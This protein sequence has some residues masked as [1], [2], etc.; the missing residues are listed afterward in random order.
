MTHPAYTTEPGP[1]KKYSDYQYDIETQNQEA[2]RKNNEELDKR[3]KKY[4]FNYWLVLMLLFILI[5]H[6]R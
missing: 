2:L 5:Y 4:L 6:F 1:P 3:C